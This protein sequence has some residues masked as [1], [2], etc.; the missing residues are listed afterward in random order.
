ML[1]R[2][3]LYNIEWFLTIPLTICVSGVGL[4]GTYLMFFIENGAWYGK[5]FFGA[6]LFFPILLFPI[7]YIFRIPLINLLSYS[8]PAG[9]SLL[10]IYKWNCYEN[11]CCGGKVLWYSEEGVPTHFPSQIAEMCV[12]IVLVIALLILE[13]QPKF[14]K[15]LYP[16][17]LISYGTVRGVLNLFRY[18]QAEFF[19]GLPAGNLWSIVSILIGV[20]WTIIYY[21]KN[22][23]LS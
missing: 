22:K 18:E 9:L 12:A 14:N 15:Y 5:S 7:S 20:T 11:G 8:T 3:K 23:E 13:R 4:V 1:F 16:I 17:C 21:F 2:H 6:V 10:A 19:F